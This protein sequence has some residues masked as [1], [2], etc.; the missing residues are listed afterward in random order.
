MKL[1]IS[2]D[3]G[4][5]E[6]RVEQIRSSAEFAFKYLGIEHADISVVILI[7]DMADGLNGMLID[8]S[9]TDYLIVLEGNRGLGDIVKTMFHECVHIKQHLRD[10]L[11]AKLDK[12][13]H[14]PY[15][16]REWEMEANRESVNMVL[17][18]LKQIEERV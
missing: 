1:T 10:G 7:D 14:I 9:L 13:K 3:Y 15:L 5:E 4:L 17:E 6:G 12:M 2:N 16:E 11:G 8:E 18:Y